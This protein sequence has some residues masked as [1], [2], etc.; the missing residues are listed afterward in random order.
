M[1]EKLEL[2]Q[3]YVLWTDGM[4]AQIRTHENTETIL[5]DDRIVENFG[6]TFCLFIFCGMI[7]KT[8]YF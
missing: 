5:A 6:V 4:S 1:K 8:A 3:V 7:R 2:V